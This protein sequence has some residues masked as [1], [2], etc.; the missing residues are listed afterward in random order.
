[1]QVAALWRLFL[2]LLSLLSCFP[3]F[4]ARLHSGA[5]RVTGGPAEQHTADDSC[6]HGLFQ[7]HSE[8]AGESRAQEMTVPFMKEVF[9]WDF[10]GVA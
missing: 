5:S 2:S 6:T 4:P 7:C 8:G 1:M 10:L 9:L 3:C